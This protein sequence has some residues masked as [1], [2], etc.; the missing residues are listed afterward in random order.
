[1]PTTHRARSLLCLL[2]AG[3]PVQ[4]TRAQVFTDVTAE[5]GLTGRSG[6]R[7]AAC[8]VNGDHYPDLLIHERSDWGAGDWW[9][10]SVLL[11]NQPGA[12]PGTRTFVDVT[13]ASGIRA[14]RD[15]TPVGR[16][17][18]AGMFA[19]VD[20]DGDLDLFTLAYLHRSYTLPSDGN[21]LLL[22]DGA[23]HFT[24]APDSPFHLEPIP[25]S[26]S[27]VFL[28][29]DN[30]SRL[31]LFLGNWY[32]NDALSRDSLYRGLGGGRFQNVTSAAG[33][34]STTTAPYGVAAFDGDGDGF[35]DLYVPSY[36]HTVPGVQ[37]REWRNNG[38]GTFR[39]VE[40]LT[41]FGAN[42]GFGSGRA[43]FGVMPRD[44][45]GDGDSDVL[46]VM[47]HGA[48]DGAAGVHTGIGLNDN[49]DWTWD[50]ARVTGRAAED[51]DVTHHGDHYA[52][53]LD[54]DNDGWVD[55]A[56]TESGYDNNRF[57][58]FHGETDGRFVAST[59]GSAPFAIN[60]A[61]LPPH[62]VLALDY[63][64]DGDQDLIVGFVSNGIDV[65]L[66]RNDEDNG[67]HWLQVFLVGGG[68]AGRSNRSAVGARVEITAGGRT[69]TQAVHVAPGHQCPQVP[70]EL[71]FGLGTADTV[72]R[73]VVHWPNAD[74]TTT[75]L[76]DV[77]ADQLLTIYEVCDDPVPVDLIYGRRDGADLVW[78]WA[79]RLVP[80]SQSWNV[81]RA[82]GPEP[83]AWSAPWRENQLDADP[84][85]G[86][87]FRDEG[88]ADEPGSY[89]YLVTGTTG[90]AETPLR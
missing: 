6:A 24:L 4:Q 70:Y 64:L 18:D 49:G 84:G 38:D 75:E 16:H 28:D 43:S 15:G 48:G 23:G 76:L 67:N 83:A 17:A 58:L 55:F 42:M 81:Y 68:V 9:D 79:Q 88:G 33:L 50:Y 13:M 73:L 51:P 34:S 90:C 1:M 74:R 32:F 53:W 20:N 80:A 65:Q 39:P 72:D 8:D 61:N 29:F 60:E 66:Y 37:S 45:D 63:D 52:T 31:D 62:N 89:Y 71:H 86:I 11:L 47:T 3:V 44:I 5:A 82:A 27:A 85:P 69:Q 35:M 22:N 40:G 46:E 59:L 2:L 10:N 54:W 14:N 21:D 78:S 30:D 26:A 25:N 41:G 12:V 77:P 19:D 56:L 87:Q 7:L 36:S 57:Y